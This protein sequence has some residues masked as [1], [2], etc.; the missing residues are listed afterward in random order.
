MEPGFDMTLH[1]EV[2]RKYNG[3][4]EKCRDVSVC[5]NA[6]DSGVA[7]LNLQPTCRQ[8]KLPS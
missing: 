7:V 6:S 4:P 8:N 5:D 2:H 3:A 1:A